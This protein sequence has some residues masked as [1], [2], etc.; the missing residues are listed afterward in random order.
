MIDAVCA[1]RRRAGIKRRFLFLHLH[2]DR[3]TPLTA[4]PDAIE[5][6][7]ILRGGWGRCCAHSCVLLSLF[8]RRAAQSLR[9]R[10]R[11]TEKRACHHLLWRRPLRHVCRQLGTVLSAGRRDLRD[12][13]F[14]YSRAVRGGGR[15]CKRESVRG[16]R[17]DHEQS[18]DGHRMQGGGLEP[19]II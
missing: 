4:T 6:P 2:A 5:I 8:W 3:T 17:N 18:I 10:T 9:R 12:E 1:Q 15:C 16:S 13:G 14:Q 7:R 11:P 19:P